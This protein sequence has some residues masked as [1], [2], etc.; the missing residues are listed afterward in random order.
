MTRKYKWTVEITVDE[1]WVADGFD[2]Q[3]GQDVAERLKAGILSY[4]TNGE[5]TARVKTGPVRE[6]VA[7]VQGFDSV[8]AM[9]SSNKGN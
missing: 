1:T 3:D 7:K 5:F 8:Y 2:L 4:A 6:L 9:D